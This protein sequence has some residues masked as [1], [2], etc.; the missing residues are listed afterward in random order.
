VWVSLASLGFHSIKLHAECSPTLGYGSNSKCAQG[1]DCGTI[2]GTTSSWCITETCSQ[3]LKC[4]GSDLNTAC[5]L[6]GC[7]NGLQGNCIACS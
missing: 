1:A 4:T 6:G 7:L 5:I 3:N 2:C